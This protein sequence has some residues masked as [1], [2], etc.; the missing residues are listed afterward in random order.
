[1]TLYKPWFTPAP[2]RETH[3]SR[4]PWVFSCRLWPRQANLGPRAKKEV[5]GN[6]EAVAEHFSLYELFA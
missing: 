3:K 6:Y 4:F 1:M 2:T 5:L